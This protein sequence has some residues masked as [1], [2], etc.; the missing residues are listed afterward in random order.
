MFVESK[1]NDDG[2]VSLFA[3]GLAVASFTAV[4]YDWV[5]TFGKEFELVWK[6]R[7]SL[8]SVLYV[9]VRWLGILYAG[10]IMLS[11]IPSLSLPDRG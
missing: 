5:L 1:S 6:R 10:T 8:M 11:G 7:C 2:D 3:C 4:V 9:S